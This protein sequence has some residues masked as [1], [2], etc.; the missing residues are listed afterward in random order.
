[1]EDS[2]SAFAEQRRSAPTRTKSSVLQ[3]GAMRVESV[4]VEQQTPSIETQTPSQHH[5][6]GTVTVTWSRPHLGIPER[7][8]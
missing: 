3:N 2:V 6:D 8:Q 1:M 4:I 5:L 7:S